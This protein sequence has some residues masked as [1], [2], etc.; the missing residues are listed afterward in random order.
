M[1]KLI[2]VLF[3]IPFFFSCDGGSDDIVSDPVNPSVAFY[4]GDSLITRQMQTY[5]TGL[6]NYI[7]YKLI[8]DDIILGFNAD[9][10]DF[11][12]ELR[13]R[14][15]IDDLCNNTDGIDRQ[16]I[17][18][19]YINSYKPTKTEFEKIFKT[20]PKNIIDSTHFLSREKGLIISYQDETNYYLSSDEPFIYNDT[21][22]SPFFIIDEFKKINPE[23]IENGI[24]AN[25]RDYYLVKVR[26]S[27][28]MYNFNQTDSII[29]RNASSTFI[30]YI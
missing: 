28:K 25:N 23:S 12:I 29:V 5:G 16:A 22:A 21:Q 2:L 10:G 9:F 15:I 26:F 6:T 13:E 27:M 8:P 4:I 18:C 19:G 24:E 1:K 14:Y 11:H 30:V 3:V 20:G 17:E 7:N